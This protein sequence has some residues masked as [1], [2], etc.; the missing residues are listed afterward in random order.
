MRLYYIMLNDP[1]TREQFYLDMEISH[2]GRLVEKLEYVDAYNLTEEESFN[3]LEN[4]SRVRDTEWV[5][6]P[7][8]TGPAWS[9][10]SSNWAK[11]GDGNQSTNHDNWAIYRCVTGQS[12]DNWGNDGD[13][14]TSGT[15]AISQNGEGVK[16]V[17]W[18]GTPQP[19]PEYN[20]LAGFAGGHTSKT[21]SLTMTDNASNF[22][23]LDYKSSANWLNE[24]NNR[25]R[26]DEVRVSWGGTTHGVI[27]LY[28]GDIFKLDNEHSSKTLTVSQAGNTV[29]VGVTNSGAA[30]GQELIWD[31]SNASLGTYYILS[32]PSTTAC[33][34][35]ILSSDRLKTENW[36]AYAN[37]AYGGTNGTY[38]YSIG[39]DSQKSHGTATAGLIAGKKQGWGIESSI[40]NMNA[41]S[42]SVIP[43]A[44]SS[45]DAR[46]KKLALLKHWHCQNN[47]EPGVAPDDDRWEAQLSTDFSEENNPTVM[48]MPVYNNYGPVLY[49][50]DG[51]GDSKGLPFCRLRDIFSLNYQN[52]V[53][54]YGPSDT[55]TL[56]NAIDAKLQTHLTL[57]NTFRNTATIAVG[58]TTFTGFIVSLNNQDFM[59]KSFTGGGNWDYQ[60]DNL[61]NAMKNR[62]ITNA[63]ATGN[64]VTHSG[65]V[66]E[67]YTFTLSAGAL[68]AETDTLQGF[69]FEYNEKVVS[70]PNF[71]S[72]TLAAN[73]SSLLDAGGFHVV[74]GAGNDSKYLATKNDSNWNNYFTL[75]ANGT[76]YYYNRPPWF[77]HDERILVVGA[78][79]DE[80]VETM[81][82]YSA[83]GPRVDVYAPAEN[84]QAAT[85]DYYSDRVNY[86]GNSTY[87]YHLHNGTSTAAPQIA[88][89]LGAALEDYPFVTAQQGHRYIV[90]SA[91]EGRLYVSPN[92]ANNLTSVNN[93]LGP[94]RYARYGDSINFVT[95][96][97]LPQRHHSVNRFFFGSGINS[98]QSHTFAT[99]QVATDSNVIMQMRTSDD[100]A[101]DG[102]SSGSNFSFSATN[103]TVY[104]V[105]GLGLNPT[106]AGSTSTTFAEIK[107]SYASSTPGVLATVTATLTHGKFSAPGTATKTWVF[108]AMPGSATG[109]SDDDY[110]VQIW[111]K[112]EKLFP[113]LDSSDQQ[114]FPVSQHTGTLTPG[115]TV[116]ISI[117]DFDMLT[118]DFHVDSS[119]NAVGS[120]N[121]VPFVWYL[122]QP[123]S[124]TLR[125]HHEANDPNIGHPA[126]SNTYHVN[127]FRSNP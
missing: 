3:L 83:R 37:D 73:M 86:E 47:I 44:S 65:V 18:D 2:E 112:E 93:P 121:L 78:V 71:Q 70:A 119:R 52:G 57:R 106:I 109:V 60:F 55:I 74:T 29:T 15:A 27:E 76:R 34:I 98:N 92:D 25:G 126:Y 48:V 13:I 90:G 100:S 16:F 32:P 107:I 35:D 77:A 108:N 81:A 31:T 59:S 82:E 10:T 20:N 8:E 42:N 17:V 1:S 95:A 28:Q 63:V 12:P 91:D 58:D 117:T 85:T 41:F 118:G 110:G 21:Y 114:M 9:R 125:V 87:K 4:D 75:S 115:N 102:I 104:G 30:Q 49:D 40:Y 84:C 50:L 6:E 53:T 97:N 127:V 94:N 14:N 62:Q 101:H 103:C 36:L 54:S 67:E 88:G 68:F 99:R 80:K 7:Q 22:I 89:I 61:N 26:N 122:T 72:S 46:T 19:H 33:R 123:S 69:T 11:P 111:K 64:N 113:R 5:D 96:V 38:D 23:I 116:D 51:T 39:T 56:S 66:Y 45:T 43:G 24:T 105:S 124:G 120:N 79:S